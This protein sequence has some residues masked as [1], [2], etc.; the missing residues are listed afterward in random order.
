MSNPSYSRMHRVNSIIKQVLA[1]EIAELKDPRVGFVTVTGVD[2]SHDLR[3]ATVFFSTLDLSK[4]EEARQA[5]DH[6]APRL[7]RILGHE[8][9]TKYT[10]A[11]EFRRDEGIVAGEK[12]ESLLRRL[13]GGDD[14]E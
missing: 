1:E 12:I 11:L 10:P 9:S 5:L 13:K 8:L 6:A 3:R 2:T 14:E 4:S 7:R